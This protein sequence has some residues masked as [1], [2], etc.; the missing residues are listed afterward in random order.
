M[1]APT[2]QTEA[3]FLPRVESLRGL[4][5]LCVAISHAYGL[6]FEKAVLSPGFQPSDLLFE[7]G[8]LPLF[9]TNGATAVVLFFVISGLVLGRSLDLRPP[10]GR[11][12]DYLSFLW[13]RAW[14]IYPAHVVVV[15]AIVLLGLAMGGELATVRRTTDPGEVLR[16]L[17]LI[18]TD[19]NGQ[20]WTLRI[21]VLMCF[22][23]PALHA[24]MRSGPRTAWAVTAAFA[25]AA[26]YLKSEGHDLLHPTLYISAFCLGL[27]V[28]D[29]GPAA[30]RAV[31]SVIR[32][33]GLAVVL[34]WVAMML[35]CYLLPLS[36]L[37]LRVQLEALGGFLLL[38]LVVWAPANPVARVLE[39][40]W[41]RWFG[42]IS[43][44]FYLWHLVVLLL[45]STA[46][47][48]LWPKPTN[49]AVALAV[50]TGALAFSLV[51]ATVLAGVSHAV[52]ERPGVGLGRRIGAVFGRRG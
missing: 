46:A 8:V 37:H 12:S 14:R 39:H 51:V 25:L 45:T 36:Q 26:L 34:A 31:L 32:R 11:L 9:L 17:L 13:R 29:F 5:A 2:A 47:A 7:I 50:D 43:F 10:S 1:T 30:C 23:F 49:P 42:R 48:V 3:G 38:S 27:L 22:I 44:S 24:V 20:T 33:P 41:V 40:P 28:W 18:N 16:N 19:L 4:A 15:L 21:E 35:P 6:V 52:V